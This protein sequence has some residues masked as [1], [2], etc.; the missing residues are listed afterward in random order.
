MSTKR[1]GASSTGLNE[2]LLWIIGGHDGNNDVLSSDFIGIDQ[3]YKGPDIPFTLSFSCVTESDKDIYLIGGRQNGSTSSDVWIADTE[4]QLRKGP[5]LNVARRL[6]SCGKMKDLNGNVLLVV[7]GGKDKSGMT[8][9]SVEVLNL[10]S[11]IS[12]MIGMF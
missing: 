1:Y 2:S 10:T 9:D 4:L 8:L 6:H 7:S 5:S 11:S 3:V 12:W